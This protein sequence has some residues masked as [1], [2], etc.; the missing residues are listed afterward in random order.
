[1]NA[2]DKNFC[3]SSYRPDANGIGLGRDTQV[4]DIDIVIA[5]GDIETGG[6]GARRP[7]PDS[8]PQR[9]RDLSL[10]L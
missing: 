1:M 3:L 6:T 2:S 10:S 7:S 4:S 9:L 8:I 5:R